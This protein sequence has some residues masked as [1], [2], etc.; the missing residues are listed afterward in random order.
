MILIMDLVNVEL[1][2]GFRRVLL[3]IVISRTSVMSCLM[4]AFNVAGTID[5]P[6]IMYPT[7]IV[8][9][10]SGPVPRL[11]PRKSIRV[12]E[13]AI[14]CLWQKDYCHYG[15]LSY[16]EIF[17]GTK[18][19]EY[20]LVC[21]RFFQVPAAF[22]LQPTFTFPEKRHPFIIENRQNLGEIQVVLL[23]S[24]FF[25]LKASSYFEIVHL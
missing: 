6:K 8:S 11:V 1:L 14:F 5:Y 4:S 18:F 19:F 3:L 25:T 7:S 24:L 15:F 16:Q 22:P 20:L 2:Q 9:N 23:S 10:C 12:Y 17:F 21:I 13:N